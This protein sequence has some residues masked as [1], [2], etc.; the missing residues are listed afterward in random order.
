MPQNVAAAI[1]IRAFTDE[2]QLEDIIKLISNDL[3]EPYSIYVYRYFLQQWYVLP[4]LR[5]LISTQAWTLLFGML[6]TRRADAS[7]QALFHGTMVGV[8]IAKCEKHKSA[9]RGYIAMLAV[10]GEFRGQ[11]IGSMGLWSMLIKPQ[12]L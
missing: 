5:W 10:K 6:P 8:V 4:V 9:F 2:S 11:K 3:S 12:G 7:I 1:E